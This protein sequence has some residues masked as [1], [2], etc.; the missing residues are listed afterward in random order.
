LVHQQQKLNH[1]GPRKKKSKQASNGNSNRR[2]KPRPETQVCLLSHLQATRPCVQ[3]Y[4]DQQAKVV[5]RSCTRT[6]ARTT[7]QR[8]T[9]TPSTQQPLSTQRYA[10]SKKTKTTREGRHSHSLTHVRTLGFVHP[11][12]PTSLWDSNLPRTRPFRRHRGACWCKN[13]S[14]SG[15]SARPVDRANR[16]PSITLAST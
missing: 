13:R 6:R 12:S 3:R 1:Y 16:S 4:I 15:G 8:L 5:D 2:P 10:T 9:Y 11:A 14:P 7:T